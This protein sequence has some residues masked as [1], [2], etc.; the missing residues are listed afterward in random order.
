MEKIETYIDGAWVNHDSACLEA[1][2]GVPS[3]RPVGGLPWRGAFH[4]APQTLGS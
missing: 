4:L 1:A 3:A 2:Q